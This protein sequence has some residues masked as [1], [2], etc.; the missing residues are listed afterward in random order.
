MAEAARADNKWIFPH[1][2]AQLLLIARVIFS[3]VGVFVFG[4]LA[5]A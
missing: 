4:T 2:T 5:V 1:L 3:G